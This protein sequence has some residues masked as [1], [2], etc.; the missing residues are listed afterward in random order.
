[1]VNRNMQAPLV[2]VA[3]ARP[4][5]IKI[6]PLLR[7]LDRRRDGLH[8]LL[9]HT[10]QHYDH[11]MSQVFFDQLGIPPRHTSLGVGSGTHGEQTGRIMERFEQLLCAMEERSAGVV[12]V[13]DVNS[14]MPCAVAARQTRRA[15]SRRSGPPV[16]RPMGDGRAAERIVAILE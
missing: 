15:L 13:G 11:G 7:S 10:G 9:V 3:G 5:F 6:A 8:P 12:V 14:T 1:M 16:V 4:N 2:L